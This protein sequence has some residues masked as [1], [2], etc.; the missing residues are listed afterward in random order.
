M[1]LRTFRKNPEE[2]YGI[3][4]HLANF[5]LIFSVI[6]FSIYLV[7]PLFGGKPSTIALIN[8]GSWIGLA[9]GLR[10]VAQRGRKG[11]PVRAYTWVLIGLSSI[12]FYALWAYPFIIILSTLSIVVIVIASRSYKKRIGDF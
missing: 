12:V 1:S 4:F 5:W 7:I 3:V 9:L 10:I 8:Y 11:L 2:V 6:M